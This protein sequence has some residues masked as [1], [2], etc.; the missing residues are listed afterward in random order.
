MTEVTDDHICTYTK[1][2]DTCQKDSG[3]SLYYND[4]KQYTIGIVSY[5]IACAANTPSV[6]TRVT[7][8]IPWIE[9]TTGVNFCKFY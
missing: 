6:A 3:G 8:Y 9:Y 7:S 1:G 4:G 2:K 5:G